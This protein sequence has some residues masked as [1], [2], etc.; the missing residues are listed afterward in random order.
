V[1][2]SSAM[3]AAAALPRGLRGR[4]RVRV[5]RQHVSQRA[6]ACT[7]RRPAAHGALVLALPRCARPLLAPQATLPAHEE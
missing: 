6:A 3:A 4:G 7:R 5:P 2:S 1:P